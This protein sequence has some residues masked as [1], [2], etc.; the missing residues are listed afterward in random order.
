MYEYRKCSDSGGYNMFMY[1]C[2]Q[3]N[4]EKE[5]DFKVQ[6]ELFRV[7]N[8]MRW[9]RGKGMIKE[10][11]FQNK[12]I[13]IVSILELLA[14]CMLIGLIVNYISDNDLKTRQEKAKANVMTYSE[15]IAG[16]IEAGITITNC[17]EQIVISEDGRCDKFYEIAKN[18]MNDSIQSIQLAPGGK[19]TEIYPEK[20]NEAGKIDLL[21]DESRG[22][23]ARYGKEHDAIVSQGPFDLK[24]G[25]KGI[26][27]R[28]PVYLEKNGQKEFWGFTIAIIRVPDI[29]SGSM[30][31]LEKF[32]YRCRLLKTT[33]PWSQEYTEVYSTGKNLVKPV[34]KQFEIGGDTW[35]LQVMPEKGWKNNSLLMTVLCG[36]I[37]ILLMLTGLT[38][39][40]MDLEEG[41]KHLRILTETDALTK[42]YNRNG[43]DRKLDELIEKQSDTHFV[44]GELDIDNFKSINDMYGHAAGDLALKSLALDMQK[45]FPKDVVIGRNG[46]DEFCLLLQNQTCKSLHDRLKEFTKSEKNFYHKGKKHSFTISLGYAEYPCHAKSRE[47]LMRCADAAL[48]E[49]KLKGKRGCTA[50]K[51]GFR[52]IRSQLGF[53]I[54]DVSE[55]L[56]GAF[57]IYRADPDNDELL[58]ANHEMLYLSGCNDMDEFL[59]YTRRRFHNLINETEQ[60]AVEESIWNQI[61]A[62]GGHE[63]DYV[64]FSLVRKDGT[65]VKVFDHGRIVENIYYGRVFYV[66]LLNEKS[67]DLHYNREE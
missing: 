25:G 20:G 5:V 35:K 6:R 14:G 13:W 43:F 28:N 60:R 29:F 51:N 12:K 9:K 63:N 3:E 15:R 40:V 18:L 17:M 52:Q 66:L 7:C 16:D 39:A 49:V 30:N 48:Y 4:R 47:E 26:A 8:E 64:K 33:A 61:N 38:I 42:I 65:Q 41:R 31:A 34:S 67:L 37:V 57:L 1:S 53:G 2:S 32:G 55:N 22:A 21:S 59:T 44:V 58:F 36:G 54:K 19:V 24:Q 10:K 23:Y 11:L 46:G 50:Y 27:V 56:P 62:D 45:H